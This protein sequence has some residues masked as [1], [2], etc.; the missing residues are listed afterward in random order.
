LKFGAAGRAYSIYIPT[1][2]HEAL[3][4]AHRAWPRFQD[5]AAQVAADNREQFLETLDR[6][7]QRM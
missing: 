7:K 5:L 4:H 1:E 6:H 3:R 2:D